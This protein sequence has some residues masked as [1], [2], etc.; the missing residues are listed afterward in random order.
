MLQG[1][2]GSITALITPFGPDG[3][4]NFSKLK[5]LIEFQVTNG[6]DGIV[7]LGTTG[8]SATMTEAEDDAV[9]RFTVE[10][11]NGRI[12]VIA[13]SGSNCTQSMLERSL[14]YQNMGV[15]G[16]LIIAP[17]YNKANEEGMYRHFATVADAVK[18]PCILYNV[19]GRTG[20]NISEG[21]V[22]RLAPHQNILGIKE[23]S[24][25]ISYAARIAKYIDD[26]F[27]LYSGNDDMIIPLLSLGGSGV[28]SVWANVQPG[29][30]HK[31]VVD[32]LNGRQQEALDAQLKYLD[33]I[34]A[35]FY[36]VNPIPVKTAM[37]LLGMDVGG[38]RLPLYDMSDAAKEALKQTMRKV[39]LL[40]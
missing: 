8:E 27:A 33:F 36:E 32:Y 35:L 28:I 26:G 10:T 23:A 38:L 7:T 16:L 34:N 24:G 2:K 12:P 37:N 14:R 30:T 3:R 40:K 1:L 4:V 22:K 21:V 11:V 31:L 5:E 15:D 25:N 9:C 18:I 19:P 20:C 39:G 17:Y 13:G 29:V 6:I